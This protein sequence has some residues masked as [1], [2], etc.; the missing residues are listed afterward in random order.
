MGL[1]SKA[2][3]TT[4]PFSKQF[5]QKDNRKEKRSPIKCSIQSVGFLH[6]YSCQYIYLLFV[7][8][9]FIITTISSHMYNT[10]TYSSIQHI[11]SSVRGSPKLNYPVC[12]QDLVDINTRCCL[13]IKAN[14]KTPIVPVVNG[15]FAQ[16]FKRFTKIC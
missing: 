9:L 2:T 6:G 12:G 10:I 13:D 3:Q 15:D 4:L 5:E 11:F 16:T 1:L 7:L 8:S 14:I